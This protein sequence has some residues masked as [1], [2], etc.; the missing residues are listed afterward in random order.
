MTGPS[1]SI[2]RRFKSYRAHHIAAPPVYILNVIMTETSA[3]PA[4][5]RT[6]SHY[7]ARW[8]IT[9]FLHTALRPNHITTLRL[10]SGLLAAYWF[11]SGEYFWTCL[12]GAMFVV[13][14]MLD[15]ADGELARLGRLSSKWGHWYDLS[16]DMV[17][18]VVIFTG[19]GFGVAASSELGHWALIMGAVSGLSIGATFAVIF[20]LHNIGSHPGIVFHCPNGFDP[21]DSLFVI[22]VFA[23]LDALLP[24][25]ILAT[26]AA[27]AFLFFALWRTGRYRHSVHNQPNSR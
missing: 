13:S 24:L 1:E 23:W 7:L 19:I 11:S 25:L 5:P 2:G 6:Y 3:A 26:V 10:L 16:C 17:V 21:D 9:P 15:R 12:G 14:T 27:P 20:R 18:N 8:M 4:P 22:A